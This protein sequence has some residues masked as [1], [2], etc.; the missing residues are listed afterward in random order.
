MVRHPVCQKVFTSPSIKLSM[1]V[2]VSDESARIDQPVRGSVPPPPPPLLTA[3]PCTFITPAL[4]QGCPATAGLTALRRIALA[5]SAANA[6]VFVAREL[7]QLPVFLGVAGNVV[8][9]ADR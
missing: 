3:M 2:S 4:A 8:P 6:T 5:F 9:S 1:G 7:A